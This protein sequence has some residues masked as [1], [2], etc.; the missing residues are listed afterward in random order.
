MT[1][2]ILNCEFCLKKNIVQFSNIK[3]LHHQVEKKQEKEN[4]FS[5]HSV[6]LKYAWE[7][8]V[9]VLIF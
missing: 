1:L 4:F 9:A 3:G 6:K 2:D 5:L 8:I 7:S